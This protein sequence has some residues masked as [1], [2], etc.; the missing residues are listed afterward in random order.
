MGN[1]I[2]AKVAD[3][4]GESLP[5][6]V[7]GVALVTEGY[8]GPSHA[9]RRAQLIVVMRGLITCNVAKGLWMVPPQCA[10]WIPGSLEHSVRCAGSVDFYILFV[11]P[12]LMPQLP[13]ECCTLAV[14]PLLRELVISVSRL[15]HRYEQDG[16][17]GRLIQTMLDELGAAPVER[18]HLPL[19][20]DPRLRRIADALAAEPSD[21]ATI[22]EW[23]RRLAMSER[24]L[25]RLI[26]Q[27]TGMSFGRWHRQFHLMNALERLAVGDA[28]HSV[29]E[30]LGYESAAAFITMFKKA[31]GQPPARYL[32]SRRG[33]TVMPTIA[34][35]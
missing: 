35:E 21:R 13:L 9:H 17:A 18:L 33:Q 30:S 25:C 6:S 34:H 23:A 32:A 28:V 4:D 24:T 2:R 26:L 14:T 1:R 22:G 11:D 15:P 27:Q 12:A 29:A 10:L 7:E 5:I 16:P 3:V 19:P 20:G 8:E 31:L